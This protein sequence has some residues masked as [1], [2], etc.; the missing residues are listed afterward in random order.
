MPGWNYK[1]TYWLSS[2]DTCTSCIL[3]ILQNGQS[4]QRIEGFDGKKQWTQKNFFFQ[5]QFD[6]AR[7]E[8]IFSNPLNGTATASIDNIQIEVFSDQDWENCTIGAPVDLIRNGGFDDA[9][10]TTSWTYAAGAYRSL[11]VPKQNGP[12]S[13]VF[14]VPV[15]P[16]LSEPVGPISQRLTGLEPFYPLTLRL[17]WY[18]PQGRFNGELHCRLRPQFAGKDL[19]PHSQS[20]IRPDMLIPRYDVR[21]TNGNSG[22][23]V[24]TQQFV[25]SQLSFIPEE[26]EGVLSFTGECDAEYAERAFLTLDSVSVLK[27]QVKC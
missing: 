9:S 27:P 15:Y 10:D 7:L 23:A 13:A 6:L 26:T 12:G 19:V 14:E 8:F 5:S 11:Y 21:A 17:W 24:G 25:L 20:E 16:K 22:Y 4:V 2:A 1:V 3:L 18:L